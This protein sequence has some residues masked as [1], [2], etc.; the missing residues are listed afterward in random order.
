MTTT[1]GRLTARLQ[2]LVDGGYDGRY[3]SY[4]HLVQFYGAWNC[5]NAL[6]LYVRSRSR[7]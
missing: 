5:C 7:T 3:L 4:V 6:G 2:S 1:S